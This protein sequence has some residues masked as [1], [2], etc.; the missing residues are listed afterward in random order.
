[1]MPVLAVF[2]PDMLIHRY[3]HQSAS[4]TR[5]AVLQETSVDIECQATVASVNAMFIDIAAQIV[6]RTYIWTVVP[7]Q[8]VVGDG[9]WAM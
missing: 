4:R 5:H 9:Y 6:A 2:L 3:A 1:M 8:L 7:E